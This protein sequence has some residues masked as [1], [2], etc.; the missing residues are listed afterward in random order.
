[1]RKSYR[2]LGVAGKPIGT[3]LIGEEEEE[4]GLLG[5]SIYRE[6]RGGGDE[7]PAGG[8][9]DRL[10]G[11]NRET[12]TAHED[13]WRTKKGLLSL[14]GIPIISVINHT[15]HHSDRFAEW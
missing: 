7:S 3:P 9:L 11:F 4:I 5:L 13:F 6:R 14:R 15:R 12:L 1:M 2:D 10:L 8:H